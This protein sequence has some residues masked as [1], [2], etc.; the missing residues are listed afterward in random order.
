[1]KTTLI[2]LC[3]A[4]IGLSA[5]TTA[6]LSCCGGKDAMCPMKKHSAAK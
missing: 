4:L 6:Q 1:M 3:I 5:C 2:L